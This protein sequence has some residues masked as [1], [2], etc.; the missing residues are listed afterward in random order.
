MKRE[1][2]KRLLT[3]IFL[4]TVAFLAIYSFRNTVPLGGVRSPPRTL[5][6]AGNSRRKIRGNPLATGVEFLDIRLYD[7]L[8]VLFI[9]TAGLAAHRA[10]PALGA[11]RARWAARPGNGQ[12][13]GL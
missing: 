8:G 11:G 7:L 12:G 6:G 4:L 1:I 10:L 2:A 13:A 9:L 5:L 3:V